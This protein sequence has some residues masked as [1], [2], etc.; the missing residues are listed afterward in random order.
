MKAV[1]CPVCNGVG[2]VSAGFYNR[3]GDCSF[4]VSTG[5]NPEPCRSCNGK[6]WLEVSNADN[7]LEP[8]NN[9]SYSPPLDYNKCPAC[10]G[11]RSSPAN[12]G[13]P[14]G[15]HYGSYC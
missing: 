13:C 5:V 2:K 1:L 3:G 7:R 10:G 12:T 4:W 8:I 14:I 15:S 9:V 11:D 6:G